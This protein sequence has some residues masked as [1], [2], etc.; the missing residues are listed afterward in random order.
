MAE[1]CGV[2]IDDVPSVSTF[3]RKFRTWGIRIKDQLEDVQESAL[4]SRDRDQPRA[5]LYEDTA[6]VDTILELRSSGLR[7]KKMMEHLKE[8]WPEMSNKQLKKLRHRAEIYLR[9]QDGKRDEEY[10]QVRSLVEKTL[11]SGETG[12]LG[13]TLATSY[14]KAE[15]PSVLVTQQHVKRAI[16]ELDLQG[17]EDRRNA[18][19]RKR[20]QYR[21]PGPNA[22]WAADGHDK[23]AEW[24]FQIYGIIDAYSRYIIHVFVSTSNRTMIAVLMYYL[25]AV[26]VFGVPLKL[27]TDK[28]VETLFMA[29]AQHHFREDQEGWEMEVRECHLF[30]PSTQN[31][32]IESWWALLVAAK[33]GHIKE[34][35]EAYNVEGELFPSLPKLVILT[36]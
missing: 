36:I 26:E 10:A 1:E 31:I 15:D 24:G 23:L 4:R 5:P 19:H 16:E 28:G 12:S 32:K 6:L 8:H 35:F 7:S 14:A 30:G 34:M 9:G 13:L 20:G 2:T 29:E 27:C 33:V 21:V 11:K 25:L 18:K 3:R 22:I 17:V